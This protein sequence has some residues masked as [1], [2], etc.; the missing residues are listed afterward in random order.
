[1]IPECVKNFPVQ[2]FW[3]SMFCQATPFKELIQSA[4]VN[5]PL[6]GPKEYRY[7]DGTKVGEMETSRADPYT[8]PVVRIVHCGEKEK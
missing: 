8:P 1:M 3:L 2:R 7:V 5:N 6:S 4:C